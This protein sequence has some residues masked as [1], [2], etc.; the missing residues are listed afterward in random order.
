MTLKSE[1]QGAIKEEM[2][3]E[4]KTYISFNRYY[5]HEG[6]GSFS[7]AQHFCLNLPR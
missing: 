5:I 2:D 7:H 4:A 3:N 1:H 6:S